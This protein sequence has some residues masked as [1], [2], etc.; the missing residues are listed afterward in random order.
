[1]TEQKWLT[2]TDPLALLRCLGDEASTRKLRLFACAC[3]RQVWHLLPDERWRGAVE[4][5][6]RFADG[7]IGADEFAA[8]RGVLVPAH[9]LGRASYAA[10]HACGRTANMAWDA[11]RAACDAA[12]AAAKKRSKGPPQGW[13]KEWGLPE[14]LYSRTS[15]AARKAVAASQAA[16]VRCIFGNS[17]RPAVVDGAWLRWND[18]CVV[19]LAQAIYEGRR[20]GDLPVL[21]DALLEAGCDDEELLAHCRGALPHAWGCWVVDLVLGS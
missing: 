12:Q 5:A 10:F 20:F 1:M 15:G 19:R 18:G 11:A 6:E 4:A 16:L 7:L 2:E 17:F 14:D 3:C 8:A 21:A 13:F 9:H